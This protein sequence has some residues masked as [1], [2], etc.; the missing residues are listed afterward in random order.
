MR[1]RLYTYIYMFT[2]CNSIP[3]IEDLLQERDSLFYE[4][5]RVEEYKIE[6]EL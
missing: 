4:E 5:E 2:I 3:V 1:R 6:H